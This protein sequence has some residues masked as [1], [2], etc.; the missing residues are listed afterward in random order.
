MRNY[1]K[2]D[3]LLDTEAQIASVVVRVF[4]EGK[5][6]ITV[7]GE[8][9]ETVA[10][11]EGTKEDF[12]LLGVRRWTVS[13][14]ELYTLTLEDEEGRR[15]YHFGLRNIGLSPERGFFL[16]AM[17]VEL[18]EENTLITDKEEELFLADRKGIVAAYCLHKRDLEDKEKLYSLLFHPSLCF[19]AYDVEEASDRNEASSVNSL[20]YSLDKSRPTMGIGKKWDERCLFDVTI[21]PSIEKRENYR[22][23]GERRGKGFTFSTQAIKK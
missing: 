12:F 3:Y 10:T 18:G 6:K 1:L 17:E 16:N 9:R 22:I 8:S 13:S 20:L 4:G 11:K 7:D 2:L 19:L 15:E 23:V 14:P 5:V 21:L